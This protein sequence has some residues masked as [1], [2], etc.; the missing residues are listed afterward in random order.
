MADPTCTRTLARIHDLIDGRLPPS[1]AEELRRHI[2]ACPSCALEEREYRRVGDLLRVAA[3][4]AAADPRLS[5][6]WARV[7]AGIEERREWEEGR[8]AWIRRFFWIPAAAALAVLFFVVYPSVVGRSPLTP[9]D[10]RVSVESL[11]SEGATV[12]L[13][14]EGEEFPRVIWILEETERG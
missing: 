11:E 12:A 13:L 14:D 2:S 1:E 4:G 10:F 6:M 8:R 3:A 7:R 9:G 5:A